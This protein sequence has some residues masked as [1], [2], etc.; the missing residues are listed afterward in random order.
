MN[1]Q[2]QMLMIV[3]SMLLTHDAVL[4]QLKQARGYDPG[5]I[6]AELLF[7]QEEK[8]DFA[9]SP[10]GGTVAFIEHAGRSHNLV[11]RAVGGYTSVQLTRDSISAFPPR[12]SLH[13]MPYYWVNDHALVYLKDHN[14][15]GNYRIYLVETSGS[16]PRCLTDFPNSGSSIVSMYTGA[17]NE[18]VISCNK[19]NPSAY[20]LY[21]LNLTSG[22][23]EM[24]YENAGGMKIYLVDNAGKLR[25]A[26]T[27]SGIL[28]MNEGTG[29]L[30]EAIAAQIDRVFLPVSF[31]ADNNF[32]IAWSSI[33]RER[34]AL[35][36]YD[37]ALMKEART[38]CE[39]SRY[40]LWS[41]EERNDA[42]F[43]T[44]ECVYA[45]KMKKLL[46]ASHVTEQQELH[47]FDEDTKA[48][49]DMVRRRLG[50]Y[51]FAMESYSE[52]FNKFIFRISSGKLKGSYYFY[53]H[54]TGKVKLLHQLSMWLP[55]KLLADV[56]AVSFASRDGDTLH[57]YLTVPKRSVLN[58]MPVLVNVHGGPHLRDTPAYNDIN[59]FFANRGYLVF[60]VNYRGSQGYGHDFL[61]AGYKQWGLRMQDDISDGIQWLIREGIADKSR[62]AIYGFSSGGYN[63]LAGLAFT[64]ELY[65][66]G[67]SVSGNV[68]LFPYF[69]MVPPFARPMI[70]DP[71]KDSVQIAATSPL[72]H[73]ERLKS[74]LLL[75]NGVKDR[76]IP[77]NEVD[78]FVD[79]LRT[80]G[81]DVEYLR[82][83]NLGHNIIYDPTS[84]LEVFAKAEWFLDKNIAKKRSPGI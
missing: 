57:G 56:Q 18:I 80:Q 30:E 34:T 65:S 21:R 64:P 53:D 15:D 20:D 16:K 51:D 82:Y 72:F 48:R 78:M 67:I 12:S 25:L 60:Q 36:E 33:G 50:N 75:V 14:G 62:I 76:S 29:V 5:L 79:K 77:I 39:D 41:L 73:T 68:N 61:K 54:E 45:P 24:I 2:L 28:R 84:K 35:V 7:S 26:R 44:A 70:G 43:A 31:S 1:R 10:D 3:V 52:D 27:P 4:C 55:E 58:N 59:Q 66:C 40:D 81:T 19:R 46:Y 38:L 63:V 32:V 71:V 37:I 49:F 22:S 83:E 9:L 47:F 42:I 8:S 23:L 17:D 11:I 6:P 13:K 74:P 69:N